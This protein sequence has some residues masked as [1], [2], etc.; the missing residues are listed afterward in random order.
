MAQSQTLDPY[1]ALND[2]NYFT[3]Q[4]TASDN[5]RSDNSVSSPGGPTVS[6]FVG[7]TVP[8]ALAVGTAGGA[9]AGAYFLGSSAV[10]ASQT[11]ATKLAVGEA[12]EGVEMLA[13]AGELLE[14]PF[15]GMMLGA[16][17][18][19]G[20]AIVVGVVVGVGAYYVYSYFR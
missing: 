9:A 15:A 4:P 5:T 19:I 10:A 13:V 12:V 7:A 6:T 1:P 18:T 17:V 16:A 8:V 14:A 11:I 20:P 2:P 3:V